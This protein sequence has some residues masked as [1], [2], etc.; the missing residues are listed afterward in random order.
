MPS[1]RTPAYVVAF[2]ALVAACSS[3]SSGSS[4]AAPRPTTTARPRTY[5]ARVVRETVVDPSY[6]QGLARV[7]GGW[8][9][10]VN[11]GLF[12]AGD[13]FARTSA[14]AP[15][16]PPE[17]QAR[18]FDHIGD[19]DVE[20][21]VLYAP[22]EQPQYELG[23]QAMLT[24]DPTTLAYTGGRTV[25]QHEASFVTVDPATHIAYSMDRFGGDALTRYDVSADW[26]VLPPLKLS[27]SVD[28]V[29]GA[30]VRPGLD[31]PRRRRGRGH[32]RHPAERCRPARAEHRREHR[33]GAGDRAAGRR[34]LDHDDRAQHLAPLH[35]VERI[36]HLIE[37]DRLGH[38][39]VEVQ[40]PGEVEVDEQREVA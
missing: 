24:Y 1:G 33:D 26:R 20:D 30:D 27:R 2:A 17:W 28:K 16:I 9:F 3:G 40:L 7:D 35:L 38:E 12:R 37:P 29:Q 23:Q 36:L 8:I 15:A 25:A 32:R 14:V 21:G 39:A 19:I 4:G 10:S 6:R 22:L 11:N 18:G 5:A 34:R 13:D 31:R